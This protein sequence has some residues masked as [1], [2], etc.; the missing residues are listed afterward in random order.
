MINGYFGAPSGSAHAGNYNDAP[1]GLV[2][3]SSMG[4]AE[5]RAECR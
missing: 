3:P 5:L 4:G 1:Y 2:A